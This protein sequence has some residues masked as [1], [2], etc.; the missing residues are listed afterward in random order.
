M[1]RDNGDISFGSLILPVILRDLVFRFPKRMTVNSMSMISC[2]I[3]YKINTFLSLC[4]KKS[5]NFNHF[6]KKIPINMD[7][8]KTIITFV[9]SNA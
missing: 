7:N 1:S 6:V 3:G 2:D 4:N 5:K 9:P 8:S